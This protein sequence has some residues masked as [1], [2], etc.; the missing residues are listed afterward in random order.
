MLAVGR[1]LMGAL[2]LVMFDEPSLG[3]SPLLEEVLHII[4]VLNGRRLVLVEQNVAL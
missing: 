4:R 1:C 2:D 3:L